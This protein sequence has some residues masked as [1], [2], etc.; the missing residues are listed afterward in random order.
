MKT[1]LF[2]ILISL[3]FNI[4]SAESGCPK[5]VKSGVFKSNLSTIESTEFEKTRLDL[6]INFVS[7]NCVSV[8]QLKTL[9]ETLNYEPHKAEVAK[10]A[11]K[12]IV[13]KENFHE[14]YRIFSNQSLIREIQEQIKS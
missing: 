1:I 6:S 2:T 13:D 5:P 10:S 9:L 4:W 8:K 3:N 7:E 11:Y 14:I 12:N